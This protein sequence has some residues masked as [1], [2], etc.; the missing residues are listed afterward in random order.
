MSEDQQLQCT[1]CG[2]TFTGKFCNRCGQ[3]E[4]HR[5]TI[6]HVAHDLV[7]VFLHADKGIVPFMK[8]L[9]IHPGI[10]GEWNWLLKRKW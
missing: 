1:N 5:I 7:H 6:A 9:L 2:N 10:K 8:R 3:K 4:A